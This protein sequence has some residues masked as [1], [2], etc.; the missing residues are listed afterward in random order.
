M[1]SATGLGVGVDGS[2]PTAPR[3]RSSAI[4]TPMSIRLLVV[5]LTGPHRLPAPVD[6]ARYDIDCPHG[7][8]EGRRVS[9]QLTPTGGPGR[10]R[11]G[12][13]CLRP[14]GPPS[15]RSRIL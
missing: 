3:V 12:R 9:F 7:T 2:A 14:I 1:P 13:P 5:M 6:A 4:D 10:H 8:S 11:S 15:T